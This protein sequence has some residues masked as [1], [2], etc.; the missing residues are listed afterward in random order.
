MGAVERIANHFNIPK[1][2]ILQEGNAL[3]LYPIEGRRK[4]PVLGEIACGDPIVAEENV[5]YYIEE[6][7]NNLPK[8]E[9]Y[10]LKAKGN[11]MEPTI[12][13]DA[14]VLIRQQDDVESGEIAAVLLN[15]DTEATLKRV[16]KYDDSIFLMPDNSE[17][18]PII[19]NENNP[20]KIIGKAV[21]I[22]FDL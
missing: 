1:S 8:G 6:P 3:N 10:Y 4:I 5:E 2:Y 13:S 15:G 9:L 14:L 11:S 22:T 21:R 16:R 12:P 7:A 19:V 20:A 18:E 17:H